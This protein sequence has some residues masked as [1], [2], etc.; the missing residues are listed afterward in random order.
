MGP[1]P[2]NIGELARNIKDRIRNYRDPSHEPSNPCVESKLADVEAEIPEAPIPNAPDESWLDGL[3][4]LGIY[5]STI[6][7]LCLANA[8]FI[9]LTALLLAYAIHLKVSVLAIR[10]CK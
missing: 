3:S 4:D 1:K 7:P 10:S 5:I 6:Q 8:V 9:V 2:A